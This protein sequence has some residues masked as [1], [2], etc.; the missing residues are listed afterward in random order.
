MVFGM[1]TNT[2]TKIYL[3]KT[4][5]L[6][7]NVNLDVARYENACDNDEGHVMAGDVLD[8]ADIQRLGITDKTSI[9]AL[10]A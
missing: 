2:E 1:E 3:S 6:L 7:G 8:D 4:G 5:E 10:V 9:Y